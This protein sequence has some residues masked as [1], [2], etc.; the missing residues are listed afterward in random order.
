[1][2]GNEWRPEHTSTLRRMAGRY[3]LAEIGAITGHATITV[4]YRHKAL[5]LEVCRRETYCKR[6]W[7]KR[8]PMRRLV[9]LGLIAATLSGCGLAQANQNAANSRAA[10]IAC[11]QERPASACEGYRRVMANDA[12]ARAAM[13][14]DG[15]CAN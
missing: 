15:Y 2:N 14:G 11:I 9:V 7:K 1:M 4:F 5:G 10:Y 6:R 3:T 12:F 8:K 13:T